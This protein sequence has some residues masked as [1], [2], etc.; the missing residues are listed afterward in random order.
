MGGGRSLFFLQHAGQQDGGQGVRLFAHV[1][2]IDRV[3][4][5][6]DPALEGG[7]LEETDVGRAHRVKVDGRVDP[8]GVV[9]GEA[10]LYVGHHLVAQPLLGVHV[11]TLSGGLGSAQVF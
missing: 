3:V 4:H 1:A 10:G 9:F 8:L 7:R 11:L 2:G 5:D 6:G